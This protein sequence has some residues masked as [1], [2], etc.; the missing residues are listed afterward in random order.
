MFQC[1]QRRETGASRHKRR[2]GE[3]YFDGAQFPPRQRGEGCLT[4]EVTNHTKE[5]ESREPRSLWARRSRQDT[6]GI[7]DAVT[8]SDAA[9]HKITNRVVIE[10]DAIKRV[11]FLINN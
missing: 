3:I 8:P 7:L 2:R 6:S 1:G 10:A 5:A 11:K 9:P 4:T